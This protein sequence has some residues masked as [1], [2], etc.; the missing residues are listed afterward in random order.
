MYGF[1]H[2][3]LLLEYI[4]PDKAKII[5]FYLT[6]LCVDAHNGDFEEVEVKLYKGT[7]DEISKIFSIDI[8]TAQ[9]YI[10]Y[11]YDNRYIGRSIEDKKS[12]PTI[13]FKNAV[14]VK[15]ESREDKDN[16]YVPN[17]DTIL[18]LSK[19]NDLF[20]TKIKYTN[21]FRDLVV[22]A[23]NTHPCSDILSAIENRHSAIKNNPSYWD[24]VDKRYYRDSL[25]LFL[26]DQEG[27]S[28]WKD[29]KE[30]KTDSLKAFQ[31]Y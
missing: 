14:V 4:I 23:L 2:K 15:D 7:S 24:N 25:L 29:K 16:S 27:I 22:N 3:D 31:Y 5:F 1:I 9:H 11:L 21:E 19:W 28:V 26:K 30:D 6:S 18:V 10:K 8:R 17:N 20:D 12:I 13:F